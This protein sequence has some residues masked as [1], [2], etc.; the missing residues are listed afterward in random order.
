MAGAL[1]DSGVARHHRVMADGLKRLVNA[2]QIAHAVVDNRNH[3]LIQLPESR[4]NTATGAVL[5]LLYP[6]IQRGTG[7]SQPAPLL[8]F[9]PLRPSAYNIPLVERTFPASRSSG[10]VA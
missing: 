6:E 3:E 10:M 2:A 5:P 4:N 7:S 9:D 1:N 8:P